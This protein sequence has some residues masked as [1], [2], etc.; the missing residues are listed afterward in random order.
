[1]RSERAQTATLLGRFRIDRLPAP[2]SGTRPPWPAGRRAGKGVWAGHGVS[3]GYDR[4]FRRAGAS[5]A[6]PIL[7][8]ESDILANVPKATGLGCR[9]RSPEPAVVLGSCVGNGFEDLDGAG[10]A[11]RKRVGGRLADP[12][13][14]D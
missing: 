2:R 12:F 13:A 11:V 4:R 14:V 9:R 1:M 8:P 5:V 10:A 7:L 3:C 6:A